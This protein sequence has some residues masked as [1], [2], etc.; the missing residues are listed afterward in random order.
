MIIY[1]NSD[2]E[3]KLEVLKFERCEFP[4]FYIKDFDN[5]RMSDLIPPKLEPIKQIDLRSIN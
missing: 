3:D 1:I 2:F 4:K 5:F